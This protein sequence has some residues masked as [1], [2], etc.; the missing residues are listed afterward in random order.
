MPEIL[1]IHETILYADDIDSAEAFY[2]DVLGL[3]RVSGNPGESVAFRLPAYDSVLLIFRPG[4]AA[5]PGRNVPTHGCTGPGHV[6]FRVAEG[7]LDKWLD[8]LAAS[9]VSI[10]L[11]RTWER[12]GRSVYVRDPAGNSVELVDGTIWPA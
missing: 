11:D 10:E 7:T 9:D 1:G 8:R 3:R 4:Y 2:R 6:A 12:G 5:T